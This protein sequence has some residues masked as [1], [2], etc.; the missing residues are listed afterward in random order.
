MLL[1]A[2]DAAIS[3]KT[4]P[5]LLTTQDPTGGNNRPL[6]TNRSEMYNALFLTSGL[7]IT[8]KLCGT[9]CINREHSS[10]NTPCMVSKKE[11]DR[12]R[13]VIDVGKVA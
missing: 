4:A 13:H 3:T 11:F 2:R 1:S 6:R 9:T 8:P 12:I 10:G 7:N 5:A